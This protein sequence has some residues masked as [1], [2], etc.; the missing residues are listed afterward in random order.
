MGNTDTGIP[1]TSCRCHYS[2]ALVVLPACCLLAL[3]G[4]SPNGCSVAL[5]FGGLGDFGCLRRP[6]RHR[7][8]LYLPMLLFLWLLLLFLVFLL[9]FLLGFDN[10]TL[11][12][13]RELL[14]DRFQLPG[15]SERDGKGYRKT[16]E[17][18]KLMHEADTH[19]VE[20]LRSCVTQSTEGGTNVDDNIH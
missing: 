5:G 20:I 12:E 10:G 6:N 4:G 1:P 2:L 8:F 18:A 7:F 9:L 3:N 14:M 11:R 13:G 15:D 17:R 19:F 16:K